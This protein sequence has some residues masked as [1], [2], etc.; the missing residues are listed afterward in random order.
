MLQIFRVP[1]AVFFVA[2]LFFVFGSYAMEAP[3][4]PNRGWFGSW[5]PDWDSFARIIADGIVRAAERGVTIV[6]EMTAAAVDRFFD[7]LRENFEPGSPGDI[8]LRRIREAMAEAARDVTREVTTNMEDSLKKL[9]QTMM[10]RAWQYGGMGV[11]F[12]VASTLGVTATYYSVKNMSAHLMRPT[13]IIESSKQNLVQMILSMYYPNQK[14]PAMV[15]SPELEQRLM[16]I[17]QAT[18]NIHQ[19]VQAGKSNVSY[20]NLMLWGPPGTGKTM[21]AKRLAK[22]SGLEWAFMSGSSFAKF[23][24]GEEIQELDKLFKWANKSKG[25]LL[26]IDEAESF[27][28]KREKLVQSGKAYQLLNNFLNHTGERSNRFMIVFATNHK[29]DI[30]SAMHRRI[31]DLVELPLPQ[32]P[33]RVRVLAL[34]KEKILLD[35]QQ[36]GQEFVDSAQ[37]C[38]HDEKIE[39]IAKRTDGLSNG[40]LAGIINSIKTDADITESGLVNTQ[41]I[42]QVVQRA[43]EKHQTF[44]GQAAA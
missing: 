35:V 33:E 25:L 3:P 44:T 1:K 18:I 36:N 2:M 27:L 37:N 43:L 10:T 13:L 9:D 38:L 42:D 21:F 26:F 4:A 15:F 31:D 28:A 16:N 32:A 8:A 12:A 30:D 14:L 7:R 5:G 20:R 24:D 17:I 19:K 41:I 34:Y 40:D 39:E 23:K 22:N 6:P 11:G 29:D